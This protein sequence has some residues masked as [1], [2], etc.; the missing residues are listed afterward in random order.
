[1]DVTALVANA[2]GETVTESVLTDSG[3]VRSG[4]LSETSYSAITSHLTD[5][6]QPHFVARFDLPANALSWE[7]DQK[8]YQRGKKR[9]TVV[10]DR[11]VFFYST[12]E[13]Y[14]VPYEKMAAVREES[15]NLVVVTDGGSEEVFPLTH[16]DRTDALAYVETRVN[17]THSYPDET[18]DHVTRLEELQ[19]MHERGL[20]GDDDFQRKRDEILDS[21]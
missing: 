18:T 7:D 3:T 10:T 4:V 14:S 6:E 13:K 2:K 15:G 12:A 1:M 5:G 17:A 9:T 11:R 20:I 19:E 8:R 16:E 21:L